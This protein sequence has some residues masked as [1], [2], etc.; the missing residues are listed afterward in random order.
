MSAIASKVLLVTSHASTRQCKCERPEFLLVVPRARSVV[1]QAQLRTRRPVLLMRICKH[2]RARSALILS[3]RRVRVVLATAA[4]FQSSYQAVPAGVSDSPCVFSFAVMEGREERRSCSE[5]PERNASKA[6]PFIHA[7]TLASAG[8]S[9]IQTHTR[10]AA[11]TGRS[12][13]AFKPSC[14]AASVGA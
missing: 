3:M 5:S 13:V 10:C 1:A 11:P 14:K 8:V 2:R 6:L 12:A 4:A 9:T 7:Q